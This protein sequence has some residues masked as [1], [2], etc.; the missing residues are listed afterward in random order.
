MKVSNSDQR[1][2]NYKSHFTTRLVENFSNY[3]KQM[4]TNLAAVIC[5]AASRNAESSK[6]HISLAK[7]RETYY[8][9]L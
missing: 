6:P 8:R 2:M 5:T 4:I 9:T 3:R 7:Q 1:K